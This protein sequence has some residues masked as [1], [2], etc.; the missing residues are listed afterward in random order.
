MSFLFQKN[1]LF[2]LSLIL[3]AALLGAGAGVFGKIALREIPP[4]SFTFLRFLVAFV[5]LIPFSIKSLPAFRK[6]DYKIILLSLLASANVVL[7]AFG[8][9]HTT[10]NIGQVIYTAVPIF[11]AVFSFYF[12]KEKF[13]ARKI[14]GIVIGFLGAGFVVFLPLISGGS[15]GSSL[16]GNL[17]IF[18]AML[19][20]SLYWVLSKKI[21]AEYT[22]MQINNYF[23]LT[24]AFC[25]L[26]L[27]VLD[28]FNSPRWWEGVSTGA[29]WSLLFVAVFCTAIYYLLHQIIVKKATPVMASMILY[30][31]PFA[32]FILSYFFLSEKITLLFL[33]GVALSFL[34][35]GIYN[36]AIKINGIKYKKGKTEKDFFELIK[37]DQPGIRDSVHIFGNLDHL[38]DGDLEKNGDFYMKYWAFTKDEHVL[39]ER[40]KHFSSTEY[41]LI[42]KGKI[43]GHIGEEPVT[44][45]T[46]EYVV[47]PAGTPNNL[48]EEVL[49]NA[50]GITIKSP[51][52]KYD[53]TNVI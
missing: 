24:T 49:E 29:Y 35:V 16:Y 43:R 9:K 47:I 33:A 50:V 2:I 42:I 7:F 19:S 15:D 51:S 38:R 14:M 41:T 6:K 53:T 12:L 25:M 32:T 3:V 39:H 34:G 27:S 40:K 21:Q 10:A 5:F 18:L 23:I 4:F 52:I 37:S 22:P 17:I 13:D 1:N 46:G 28:F 45:G 11:S 30:L 48:V 44:L 36:S 31:Q 20:I 26:F 8:I